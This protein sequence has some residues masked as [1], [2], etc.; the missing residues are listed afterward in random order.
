MAEAS[1]YVNLHTE[2]LLTIYSLLTHS[3]ETKSQKGKLNSVLYLHNLMLSNAGIN[4]VEMRLV[5]Q[6]M[7]GTSS[8]KP[9]YTFTFTDH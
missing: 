4:F 7:V 8:S 5:L 9:E 6:E 2:N 1:A 3:F